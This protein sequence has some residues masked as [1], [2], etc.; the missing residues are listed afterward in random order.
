MTL[1]PI[2]DQSQTSQRSVADYSAIGRRWVAAKFESVTGRRSIADQLATS[3][4]SFG[5]LCNPFAIE[6]SRGQSFVHVQKTARD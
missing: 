4:R 3:Q 6:F 5:D 1:K 2:R